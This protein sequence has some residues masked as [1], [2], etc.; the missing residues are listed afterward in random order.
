MQAQIGAS[1]SERLKSQTKM[2][3]QYATEH[4]HSSNF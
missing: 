2:K 1:D 3:G 4:L